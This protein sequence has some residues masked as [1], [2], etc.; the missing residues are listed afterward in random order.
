MLPSHN[1]TSSHT[2][3]PSHTTHP[4]SPPPCFQNPSTHSHPPS[5]TLSY[6]PPTQA[7]PT[8]IAQGLGLTSLSVAQ[9][10]HVVIS[11][12]SIN[13]YS[14]SRIR[15]RGLETRARRGLDGPETMAGRG[16]DRP[17]TRASRGLQGANTSIEVVYYLD[18][19]SHNHTSNSGGSGSSSGSNSGGS[20]GGSSNTPSSLPSPSPL[21]PAARLRLLQQAIVNGQFTASLRNLTHWPTLTARYYHYLQTI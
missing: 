8:A 10:N 15:A 2:N 7:M 4:L 12:S 3:T 11:M 20:S 18:F 21:P 14:S 13:L 5:P 9:V 19:P 1:N 16:L 6:P 17:E